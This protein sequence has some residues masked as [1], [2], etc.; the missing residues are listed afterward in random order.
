M[1]QNAPLGIETTLWSAADKLRGRVD[2]GEYKHTV[3]GLVFLK[4][5]GDVVQEAADQ[6]APSMA[7][8]IHLPEGA[9]WSTITRR[10]TKDNVAVLIDEAMREVESS[11]PEI[12]GALPNNYSKSALPSEALLE[13]VSLFDEID[14]GGEGSQSKDIL[15][16][17]YE[18]FIA[19]FATAEG[20]RGG[21]FYTPQ[22]VV[23][24]LVQMLAPYKGSVYDP[25]CGSGGLF[26]QSDRF[27]KAHGIEEG[28]ITVYG[29]E[30]NS[31][32]WRL[33]KM[34]LA[35]QGVRGNLGSKPADSFLMDLHPNLR[36][37]YILANPPF[38]Q[39]DWGR[40]KLLRDSRWKY[41][42]PPSGN[43]NFA[44]I[45]HIIHHLSEDG[46]A[47]FV[48]ANGS[49]STKQAN[50]GALRRAIIEADLVDCVVSLPGQLFYST[51]IPVSLWFISQNKQDRRFRDRSGETLFID[52]RMLGSMTSRVHRSLTGE[53]I[54]RISVI[55]RSW[56]GDTGMAQ[57][58]DIP[59][60]AKS[61][62]RSDIA[63][64]KYALVPGRFVGFEGRSSAWDIRLLEREFEELKGS[65]TQAHEAAISA[66]ETLEELLNGR[67]SS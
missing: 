3:L 63:R 18:Y 47:G 10:A 52:A 1:Q 20:L 59:G 17:V 44:W 2:P 26:V 28:S 61:V 43:A 24:L 5:A 41:G 23:R 39:S 55:Y 7:N 15:G 57:Y 38:N 60:F 29:Q 40:A 4:F 50:E 14:L 25:C 54:D 62:A 45:Q 66:I 11:N 31:K 58:D 37:D 53:E 34:N 9:L 35:L 33:A 64:H 36:A 49:L 19:Q 56:R 6:E 65:V 12:R 32:T 48:L 51:Q 46:L 16:R 30:S 67:A 8:G 27:V 22:S 13:L 21:E 42:I